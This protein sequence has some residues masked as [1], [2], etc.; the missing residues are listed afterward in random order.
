MHTHIPEAQ[1]VEVEKNQQMFNLVSI[2]R[3]DAAVTG[4]PAAFQYART[5]GGVKVL[6]VLLDQ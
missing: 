4:K 2:G 3:V 6:P 5:R 1:T